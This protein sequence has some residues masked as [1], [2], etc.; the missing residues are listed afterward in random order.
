MTQE[1]KGLEFSLVESWCGWDEQDTSDFYFYDVKL[2][3]DVFGS[4]FIAK[5]EGQSLDLGLWMQS[6]VVEVYLSDREI[7]EPILKRK[8]KIVLEEE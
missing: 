5:Y 7:D 1:N 2:R 3:E 6:S 8:I 4:D